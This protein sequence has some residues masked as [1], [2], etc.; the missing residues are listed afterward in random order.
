LSLPCAGG[1]RHDSQNPKARKPFPHFPFAFSQAFPAARLARYSGSVA[2]RLAFSLPGKCLTR[3]PFRLTVHQPLGGPCG[4]G[5]IGATSEASLGSSPGF[6]FLAVNR[7]PVVRAFRAEQ[8]SIN[9][10]NYPLRKN[11][12]SRPKPLGVKLSSFL[13]QR[14]RG[15]AAQGAPA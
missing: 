1:R 11:G 14:T 5:S 8:R 4:P 13:T 3:R 6:H 12:A 7:L 2:Y 10:R 15:I 9:A